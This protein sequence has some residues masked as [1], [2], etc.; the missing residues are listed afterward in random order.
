MSE[1]V[2]MLRIAHKA[3]AVVQRDG[4]ESEA[5]LKLPP[6]TLASHVGELVEHQAAEL[7]YQLKMRVRQVGSLFEALGEPKAPAD[8]TADIG[9]D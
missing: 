3:G 2:A 5:W 6:D 8:R 9:D 7:D 4:G 1:N